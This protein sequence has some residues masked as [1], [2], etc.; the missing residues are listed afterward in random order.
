MC[1]L[2]HHLKAPSRIGW[3]KTS[4]NYRL[5]LV[6]F[7]SGAVFIFYLFIFSPKS[8]TNVWSFQVCSLHV[9]THRHTDH[10]EVAW[11]NLKCKWDSLDDT[12]CMQTE[13]SFFSLA[14]FYLFSFCLSCLLSSLNA[15]D[16]A[17][18]V[19]HTKKKKCNLSPSPR[20]LLS[21]CFSFPFIITE[22]KEPI[23]I[24][25]VFILFLYLLISASPFLFWSQATSQQSI[26]C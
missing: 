3:T 21:Q 6:S 8:T 4:R 23:P 25:C 19:A 1:Q 9:W 10:T 18:S 7:I 12:N 20:S 24:S 2:V 17:H 5:I 22:A 13:L 16:H 15:H 11:N 14:F 26:I